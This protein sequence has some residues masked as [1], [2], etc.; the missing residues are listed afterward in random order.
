MMKSISCVSHGAGCSFGGRYCAPRNS[1]HTTSES[2]STAPESRRSAIVGRFPGAAKLAAV[3]G[4]GSI[5]FLVLG[6]CQ[7]ACAGFAIPIAQAFGAKDEA[8]V[9]KCVAASTY[10]SAAVSIVI[11]VLTGFLCPQLLRL[12]NTPEDILADAVSYI[13]IIF[14]ASLSSCCIT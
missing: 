7:G 9:R 11:A 2:S 14:S 10:L 13:R 5:N 3:G 4:T 8:M 6:F 1:R 12:M